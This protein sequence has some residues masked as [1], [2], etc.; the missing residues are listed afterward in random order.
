MGRKRGPGRLWGR[1]PEPRRVTGRTKQN[2]PWPSHFLLGRL[3]NEQAN[4][5]Q[6]LVRENDLLAL[7]VALEVAQARNARIAA[8]L[9]RRHS[10]QNRCAMFIN[11]IANVS[12]HTKSPKTFF[13]EAK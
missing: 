6:L 11:V 8:Q 5:A 10:Q 1:R 13:E 2:S 4:A 9:R 12:V 3:R 7:V